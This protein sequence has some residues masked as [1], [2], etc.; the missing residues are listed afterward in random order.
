[1]TP[2]SAPPGPPMTLGNMREQGVRGMNGL[3][4]D[5]GAVAR[6]EGLATSEVDL[7]YLFGPVLA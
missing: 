6:Q 3:P 2:P 5:G 1:M 7:P 4:S